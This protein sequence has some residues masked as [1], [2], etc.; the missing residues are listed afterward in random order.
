MENKPIISLIVAIADNGIIGNNNEMPWHLPNDF[1]FFKEKT[2]NKPV[3]MGRKTFESIGKPLPNRTNIILSRSCENFKHNDVLCFSSLEKAIHSQ[4]EHDEI[5]IIGGANIYCQSIPFFNRLY[6]TRVHGNPV[7]DTYLN[8]ILNLDFT[9]ATLIF[10][11]KHFKDEK[12]AFDY[13]SEIW[14]F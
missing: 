11:E 14:D 5:M 1:K 6:L 3:L 10:A 9:K 4:K 12:H 7:G 2:L 8:E 13:T